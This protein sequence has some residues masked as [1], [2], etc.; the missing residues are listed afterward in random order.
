MQC[1]PGACSRLKIWDVAAAWLGI[2]EV[3]LSTLLGVCKGGCFDQTVPF[4]SVRFEY[5]QALFAGHRSVSKKFAEIHVITETM[6]AMQV[7][8]GTE[9]C[10]LPNHAEV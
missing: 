5:F 10:F 4:Y 6:V 2:R 7:G 3:Y 1:A 9:A 8:G